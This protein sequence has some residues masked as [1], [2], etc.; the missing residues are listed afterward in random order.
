[1]SSSAIDSHGNIYCSSGD[2]NLY[3][4]NKNGSL[5]WTFPVANLG[6]ESSPVIA[7]DGTI[8]ISGRFEP[9][10]SNPSHSLLYA[11]GSIN[12][13]QPTVP[14]I[15]GTENG[16][17][18]RTYEYTITAT[19]LDNDTL[20]YYVDWGDGTTTNWTGPTPSGQS[21]IQSHTWHKRGTYTVKAKAR[22]QYLWET[23]WATL[24]IKMPYEPPRFPILHWL[25]NR[26]PDAFPLLHKLLG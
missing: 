3:A 4:F 2:G 18:R 17:V 6:I 11:L 25:L 7:A 16:H 21:I 19:D 13:T 22:D 10:G 24:T 8:Y 5:R 14:T 9:S 1:M 12:D 20:S 15:T 23:D 26:F